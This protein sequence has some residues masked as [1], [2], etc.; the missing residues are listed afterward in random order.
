MHR[1][2]S[3]ALQEAQRR[4]LHS[5]DDTVNHPASWAFAELLGAD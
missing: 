4:L 3:T 1:S 5:Q 2:P